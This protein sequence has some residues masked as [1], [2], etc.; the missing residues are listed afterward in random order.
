MWCLEEYQ[1]RCIYILPEHK[2]SFGKSI[3]NIQIKNDSTISRLHAVVSIEPCEESELQYKCVICDVSKYGTY[4]LR[5]EEKK[6]LPKDEKFVLKPDDKVQFGLK[7]SIFIVTYHSF[8]VVTS[9]LN[10]E[11][12]AKLK[13]IMTN[14]GG[15]L[16]D[17]WNVSCTHLTVPKQFLFTTKLACALASAKTIVTIAYWEAVMEA[18]EKTKELPKISDFLPTVNE[19][20][21][22]ASSKL[23]LPKEERKT[24]FCGLFFVHFCAK[25]YASYNCIIYA[26]GGRSCIYPTKKPLTPRDLMAKNAVIIQ[27]PANDSSQFTVQTIATDY[28][29]IHHKL[30]VLKRRMISDSEIPLAILNCSTER[31]CNPTFD[32]GTLLK[33]STQTF[34][35]S[36]LVIVED[37]QDVPLTSN[38]RKHESNEQQRIIPETL[39]SPFDSDISKR[40][41]PE[42]KERDIPGNSKNGSGIA[43]IFSSTATKQPRIIPETCDSLDK[44]LNKNVANDNFSRSSTRN[45]RVIPESWDKSSVD[46]FSVGNECRVKN[47]L[48]VDVEAKQQEEIILEKTNNSVPEKRNLIFEKEDLLLEDNNTTFKKHNL[49]LKRKNLS[50]E[51]RNPLLEKNNSTNQNVEDES[52]SWKSSKGPRIVSIEKINVGGKDNICTDR[53]TEKSLEKDCSRVEETPN[54]K[55]KHQDKR[56]KKVI[57]ENKGDKEREEKSRKMGTKEVRIE[58]SDKNKEEKPRKIRTDWYDNYLG[59][60]FTDEILRKSEPCGKRFVKAFVPTPV[61][62][63]GSDDFVL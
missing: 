7:H 1:G 11:E 4:I 16:S 53:V 52:E 57:D 32:F 19:N 36:G 5:N 29:I 39:D 43:C 60:E 48:Q 8:V 17:S 12:A 10:K 41:R 58:K 56:D 21:L 49:S 54:L 47:L 42:S 22:Q 61:R 33:S 62:K 18:V 59:C 40:A 13:S 15:T 26:A 27:Q 30:S 34:S 46:D 28:P 3:S 6:R 38:K 31:F 9:S 51:K 50:F 44:T 63:L 14:L 45:P 25:Q 2:V 24:L 20:W 35:P 55:L 37:T 23:F